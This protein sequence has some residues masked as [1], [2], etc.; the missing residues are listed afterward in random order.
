MLESILDLE[1]GP[2]RPRL[3]PRRATFLQRLLALCRKR[4]GAG[5]RAQDLQRDPVGVSKGQEE[6]NKLSQCLPAGA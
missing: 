2:W 3:C 6:N 4:G 1:S 5:S